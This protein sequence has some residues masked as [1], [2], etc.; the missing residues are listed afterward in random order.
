MLRPFGHLLIDGEGTVF[1]EAKI[2]NRAAT[3]R[4]ECE[5]SQPAI[6]GRR[7]PHPRSLTRSGMHHMQFMNG[8]RSTRNDARGGCAVSHG[9]KGRLASMSASSTGKLTRPRWSNDR[10]GPRSRHAMPSMWTPTTDIDNMC[11][12]RCRR[13]R[14]CHFLLCNW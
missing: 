13:D 11:N 12:T 8:A 3:K 14:W 7:Q 4:K 2:K 5:R 1:P 9:C 6:F 10:G